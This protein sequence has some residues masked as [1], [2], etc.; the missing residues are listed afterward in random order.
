M[1]SGEKV[2]SVIL[3]PYLTGHGGM[4]TVLVDVVNHFTNSSLVDLKVYFSQCVNDDLFCKSFNSNSQLINKPK[5]QNQTKKSKIISFLKLFNFLIETKKEQI[6]CMS[7]M[8][9]RIAAAAKR[10]F[11]KDYTII[12]WIHFSL[13]GGDLKAIQYLKRADRH[14]AISSGIKRQLI[15]M[16]VPSETIAVI[17][18]PVNT[19]VDLIPFDKRHVKTNF[20][21]I[22][23]V[24]W[25]GQKNLRELFNSL[26]NLTGD[27]QLTVVGSGDDQLI[28]KFVEEHNLADRVKLLGWQTN[29]WEQVINID[30]SVLSSRFEGLPMCL[31]ESVIRGIPIVSSDCP[32]GPD[33]L[34][35]SSINGY[36]YR[37]GDTG[38]LTELLQRFIDG[39][40]SFDRAKVAQSLQWLSSDYYYNRLTALL[41]HDKGNEFS[42]IE[43]KNL[44]A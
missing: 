30:C 16:G 9:V 27:W 41:I 26:I 29:P 36:I 33:D 37:L 35:V 14:L 7:P 28:S 12:S 32:T 5:V 38:S 42:Q 22:G 39:K 23:R 31:I 6:I 44:K 20:L 10:L 25:N 2:K 40:A 15:K 18:N 24:Q 11:K 4:E 34:V 21:Y 13:V 43:I 8:L 17:Y 19:K 1:K 3:V